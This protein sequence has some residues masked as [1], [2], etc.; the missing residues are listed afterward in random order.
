MKG[1]KHK[2]FVWIILFFAIILLVA[3]SFYLYHDIFAKYYIMKIIYNIL[4]I[5]FFILIILGAIINIRNIKKKDDK[6]NE[7]IK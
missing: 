7:I 6:D 4:N 3:F 2:K 5:I 1:K